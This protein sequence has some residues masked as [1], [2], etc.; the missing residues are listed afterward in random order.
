MDCRFDVEN[1]RFQFRAGAVIIEDGCVLLA[2]SDFADY[3]YSVGG[4]VLLGETAEQ[5]VKREIFEETG[6][7]Y[8]A[9]RLVFVHENFFVDEAVQKGVKFHEVSFYYLMKP[10]GKK[11]DITKESFCCAGRETMHW[12]PID[13][14]ENLRVFPEFFKGNLKNLNN[15]I[16]H[17]VSDDISDKKE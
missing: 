7:L 4:A 3:Y 2:K 17:F 5:A 14:L 15:G 1:E 11:A 8:E 16:M 12:V 13:E 10:L 9:E 6:L